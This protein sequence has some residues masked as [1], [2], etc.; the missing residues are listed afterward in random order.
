M[1]N[2]TCEDPLGSSLGS[3]LFL[4][5]VNDLP[6]ITNF[7]TTLFADIAC[8][9]MSDQTLLVLPNQVNVELGK[10][11]C[12]LRKNKLALNYKKTSYIL[13]HKQ[14]Q[15]SVLKNFELMM[16]DQTLIK[17]NT[18]KYLGITIDKSLTWSPHQKHV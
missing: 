3:L 5:Y 2:V 10:K 9:K 7:D 6:T 1:A 18:A 4:I 15:N 14:P 17:T 8:L 12:W 16:N 11:N 13:V